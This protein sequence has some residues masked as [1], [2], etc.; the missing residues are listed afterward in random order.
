MVAAQLICTLDF[1][2]T[3]DTTHLSFNGN[4]Q[5]VPVNFLRVAYPVLVR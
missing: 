2:Y 5:K 4:V 3:D 1:A